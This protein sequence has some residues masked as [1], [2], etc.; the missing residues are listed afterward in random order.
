MDRQGDAGK[1]LGLHWRD[2]RAKGMK[3]LAV[4]GTD[5]HVHALISLPSSLSISK[6]AQLIKGNSS[7][8]IHANF[9]RA[10]DFEWQ[11][12]YG[13]FSI[14]ASLVSETVSYIGKQREHHRIV[15]F[16]EE[17]RTFLEKHGI[18]Y[19]SRYVMG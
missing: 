18:A 17:Y 2:W 12:G 1:A 16:Q 5:D 9:V 8:W 10:S 11:R 7:S 15:S 4:G 19:D 14:G 3:S 13:A 6:A